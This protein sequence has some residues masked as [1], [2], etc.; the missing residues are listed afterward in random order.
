MRRPTAWRGGSKAQQSCVPATAQSEY[1]EFWWSGEEILNF[2]GPER[3]KI[4]N[5][6]A[7]EKDTIEF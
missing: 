7:P 6:S 5:F 1:L 4:F 2:S 3:E